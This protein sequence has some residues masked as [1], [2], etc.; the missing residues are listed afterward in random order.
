MRENDSL[1]PSLIR[2]WILNKFDI[3]RIQEELTALGYDQEYISEQIKGFKKA[4]IAKRQ[5]DGFIFLAVGAVLGFISCVLTII[6]PIPSIYYWILYGL[7][8]IAVILICA[9]LYY[10]FE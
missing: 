6:N 10:L 8:S 5:T 9:G 3:Q 4:K 2:Q 1:N 7:T